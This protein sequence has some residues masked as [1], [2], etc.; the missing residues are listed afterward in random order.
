M[1]FGTARCT[2]ETPA[3]R[4]SRESQQRSGPEIRPFPAVRVGDQCDRFATWVQSQGD[5]RPAGRIGPL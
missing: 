5:S 3:M 2:R 1:R 4:E